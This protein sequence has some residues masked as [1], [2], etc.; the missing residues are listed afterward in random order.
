[1]QWCRLSTSYYLD[2]ALLRAGEAA[3][4]LFLRCIAY[5]GA[6]ETRGRVPCHVLPMLTPTKAK[7]R[8]AALVR[9]QLVAVDGDHVV[10]RSWDRW[11]ESLDTESERRRKDRERK[12]RKR[13]EE[14]D[15]ERTGPQPVP[16]PSSSDSAD[17]SAEVPRTVHPES[18]RK[19]VEVEKEQPQ[20]PTTS[21]ARRGG[22][23]T[24]GPSTVVAAYV[25]ACQEVA[26][27]LDPRA[28]GRIAKDAAVLLRSGAPLPLLVDAAR[29]LAVN[30]YADLGAE[31]RRLHAARNGPARTSTTDQRVQQGLSLVEHFRQQEGA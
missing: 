4:V 12:A 23:P 25:D 18:A 14:L 22:D 2:G 21:V 9:E 24:P 15:K 26:G 28:K 13:Q 1:M 29:Q 19:E 6:Q 3:E 16:T 5:A 20:P 17:D 27:L 11:Q 8:L 30:G 10:I 7:P 31:A